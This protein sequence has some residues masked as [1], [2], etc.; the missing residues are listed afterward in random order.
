MNSMMN[1][2]HVIKLPIPGTKPKIFY[3][4]QATLAKIKVSVE[5]FIGEI[6]P[7]GLKKGDFD[8][9]EKPSVISLVR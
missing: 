5:A 9:T 8:Y 2:F 1:N 7:K 3:R 4:H 6:H